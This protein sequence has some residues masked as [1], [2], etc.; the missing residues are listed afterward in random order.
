MLRKSSTSFSNHS[1]SFQNGVNRT[2]PR[3]SS[4]SNY[5]SHRTVSTKS[6]LISCGNYSSFSTLKTHF[7]SS[8]KNAPSFSLSSLQYGNHKIQ[9]QQA[10]LFTVKIPP[11]NFPDEMF[12]ER[13][14]KIPRKDDHGKDDY[15]E[16]DLPVFKDKELRED[17]EHKHHRYSKEQ[18]GSL[19][20]WFK[21]HQVHPY[22]SVEERHYLAAK[23]GLPPKQV[24]Q[25]LQKRREKY[26]AKH[27][28]GYYGHISDF[29]Q[30]YLHQW[31][32]NE[33]TYFPEHSQIERLAEETQL[34]F[35]QVKKWFEK[36]QRSASKRTSKGIQHTH[37]E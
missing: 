10:R 4:F 31:A 20:K 18:I 36:R 11:E 21:D 3:L 35:K 37:K 15:E 17:R 22:P 12:T 5:I 16:V 28:E 13:K 33:G 27:P 34:N 23:T 6:V 14:T 29:I 32:Q 9:Q 30:N 8:L 24:K 26:K 1:S 7:S 19:E 25:Y 2:N